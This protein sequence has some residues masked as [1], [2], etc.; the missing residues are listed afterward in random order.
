MEKVI[1]QA[2]TREECGKSKVN[3]LRKDGFVPAVC[4]KDGN[5]P[6]H[7][8]VNGRE[9]FKTLHTKAGENVI[10]SLNIEDSTSGKERTVILKEIQTDPIKEDIIHVDFK[11]I[12]LTEKIKVKVPISSRGE[13]KEVTGA[14]GVIEHAIWELDIECLPAEIPGKIEVD[15]SQMK[16]GDTI[17]IKDLKVSLGV[18]ILNDPELVVLTAKPPAKEDVKPEGPEGEITEPEVIEKGKKEEEEE[19]FEEGAPKKENKKEDKKA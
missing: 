12:S 10:I 2:K 6:I 4:Y 14:D 16:I 3:K 13:A 1:L 15:V 19:V 9:L 17:T 8:K 18:R 11:E 5:A 7:I